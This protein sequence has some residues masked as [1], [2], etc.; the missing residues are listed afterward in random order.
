[1][2]KSIVLSHTTDIDIDFHLDYEIVSNVTYFDGYGD[3][4]EF[5]IKIIEY[6]ND[7]TT[8][9]KVFNGISPNQKSVSFLLQRFKS[10]FV[11]IISAPD[12]IEDFIVELSS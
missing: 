12:I 6:Y 3:V 5:G 8:K 2:K 7:G 10:G 1:M 9:Q 11:S 4:E